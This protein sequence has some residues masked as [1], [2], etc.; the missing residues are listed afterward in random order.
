ML[1]ITTTNAR[2]GGFRG[3]ILADSKTIYNRIIADGGVSNLTRL[4][5][6]VKGLKTIYGSLTNVPVCY[7]AH[8][9]GYKLGS[10]T[11]A[12]AGQAAAKLY[13][14][15]VAG[16]AVQT[17]A[18]SQPL[19]LSHNGASSDNYWYSAGTTT[20]NVN[21]PNISIPTASG[22]SIETK[23][24][25]TTSDDSVNS[26][27]W[28]C[29][30]DNGG[31]SRSLFLG[32]NGQRT[33]ILYWANLSRSAQATVQIPLG[34]N[35]WIKATLETSGL[36][37]LAKFFTSSDGIT[38][39]QLGTTITN[40]AG[41]NTFQT[42]SS[43]FYVAGNGGANSILGKIFRV[44]YKDANGVTRSDFNPATYN[45]A[46]SQT[47]WTSATGEI[48]TISTGTAT[49]GYKGVL[50]DRTIV[51]GDGVDDKMVSGTITSYQYVSRYVA[52]T[53]YTSQ[54][55]K[56][57]L[58]GTSTGHMIYRSGSNAKGIFNGTFLPV[59]GSIDN[60]LQVYTQNYNGVTS[61]SLVDN[62]NLVSGN[63]GSSSSTS[64]CLF[65]SDL[66]EFANGNLNTIVQAL[67]VDTANNTAT[68]NL[69][70]TL[71][72]L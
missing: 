19:L 56:R 35:G 53:Q 6:F 48:W 67:N 18:A 36:D 32:F 4:N 43:S 42:T 11:G 13:S 40:I 22:M 69:L 60:K 14:L 72:N 55:N 33:L 57:F 70:K 25:F 54:A 28:I 62:A 58:C 52:L 10:G 34:F 66:G 5:F 50:V 9:I 21:T 44:I 1:G 47:A 63:T 26:S 7:D 30:N 59:N 12:T 68:Y 45:A 16:D 24:S 23:I 3:G 8:W 37:M 65:T 31:I 17:T 41:A 38:Y 39:S 15:T 2:V 27:G 20:G 61:S 71:N 46:T 51:Q 29:S 49:T 64:M